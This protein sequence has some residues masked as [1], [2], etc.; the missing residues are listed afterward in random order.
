M[1]PIVHVIATTQDGTRA[2]VAAAIP[3]ARGS[4]AKLV[5]LVPRIVSYAVDL[6]HPAEFS[7]FFVKHYAEIV[8]ELGGSADIEVC[9]C[10]SI[11]D[12]VARVAAAKSTV[13]VGGPVGR[14]LTSPEERFTSRLSRAGCSA[15]FVPNG[16]NITQRRTAPVVASLVALM[17]LARPA[18]AQDQP[19]YQYGGFVDVGALG[20]PDVPENHLFRN[21][22]TTPYVG[23][24][25][26]NMTA[27]YIRKTAEASSRFGFEATVQT[28]KDSEVFGF[29]NV[30]PNIDGADALRHF[31]PTDISYLAPVGKGLTIQGGIF[32]S[33]IGYDSLYS[34]DNLNYTRPWGADYTPYLMMGVNAAYPVTAKVTVTGFVVNDYFHLSH[35]NGVPSVGGQFACKANDQVTF[36]ETMLYGPHQ[37]D[38]AIEYWRFLSDTWVE[39][40][41]KAVTVALEYQFGSEEVAETSSR[42]QWMS[43]QAPIQW[44]VSGPWAL[45][46]R[47]E[48]AWDR[49]GRW[50]GVPE[51]VVALTTTVEYRLAAHGAQAILRGEYRID[52]S[53]G[54]GGGFF[55][56]PDNHLIPTQNLVLASAI[57]TFDGMFK[58]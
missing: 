23:E 54:E 49:D 52:N 27:A 33:L 15:I 24:L 38:T 28:G 20:V 29:S 8:H 47:P 39:R 46:I 44:R 40:K 25:D 35:P 26:V 2:A 22:G 36:K 45:T 55:A 3:L 43:A 21:R 13:V 37:P 12:I 19:Q 10:R 50:I 58:R 51:S 34:K 16:T 1:E 11:D 14:W 53:S 9:L 18:A 42:A 30:E 56:G 41:T 17:A 57:V 6:D 5:V 4:C 32:G 48:F 7:A 31:G